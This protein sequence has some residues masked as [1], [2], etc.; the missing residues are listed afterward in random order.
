MVNDY[1]R[2]LEKYLISFLHAKRMYDLGIISSDDLTKI[3]VNLRKKYSIKNN[4]VYLQ[5]DWIKTLF[6][7][8]M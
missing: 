8:N 7:G 3:D 6:R 4:S 5:I 2:N 1:R